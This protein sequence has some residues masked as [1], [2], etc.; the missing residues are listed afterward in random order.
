MKPAYIK[1]TKDDCKSLTLCKL[2]VIHGAILERQVRVDP[3][4]LP[5]TPKGNS[6]SG[7]LAL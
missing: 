6:K 5:S 2:S 4:S 7:Q 3:N 1:E